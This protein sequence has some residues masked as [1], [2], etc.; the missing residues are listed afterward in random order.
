MSSH[1]SQEAIN[2]HHKQ[3]AAGK[4]RRQQRQEA[5][6]QVFMALR[7]E[8]RTEYNIV[9]S[10]GFMCFMYIMLAIPAYLNYIGRSILW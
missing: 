7:E 4:V 1:H 10:F 2:L 8:A 6:Q 9:L 3:V 5:R